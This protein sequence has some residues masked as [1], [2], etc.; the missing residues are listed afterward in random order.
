MSRGAVEPDERAPGPVGDR[1]LGLLHLAWIP[2]GAAAAVLAPLLAA[3]RASVPVDLYY[4]LYF[5]TVL[6]FLE[7]YR[8]RTRLDVLSLVRRRLGWALLLGVGVGLLMVRNVLSRPGTPPLP[9]ELLPLALAWRGLA[10]GAVDGLILFAFP[11][12]VAW[13]ALGADHGTHRRRVGASLLAWALVLVMT[14]AYHLGYHDFRWGKILQPNIGSGI[15]AVAT[16]ASANPA[17]SP[18]AHVMLHVAAV[19]HSPATDLFLPPHRD[20]PPPDDFP[21]SPP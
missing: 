21:T 2:A 18:L 20:S 1:R 4:L 12:V 14:T 16:L 17:A 15:T 11:W 19:L 10:Y 8:R 9:G 3:D 5:V 7:V 13:R 6:G